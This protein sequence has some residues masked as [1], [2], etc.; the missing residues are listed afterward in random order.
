MSKKRKGRAKFSPK[1]IEKKENKKTDYM[2]RIEVDKSKLPSKGLSYP[3]S[4]TISYRPYTW[5]EVKQISQSKL[6]H[7]GQFEFIT[8]GIF[9][10]GI[11]VSD[12]TIGDAIYLGIYRK[13]STLGTGKVTIKY[14][15]SNCK[16][17]SKFSVDVK[18]IGANF[19]EAPALPMTMK[20]GDHHRSFEPLSIAKYFEVLN[21]VQDDSSIDQDF[22][23]YAAQ[24]INGEFDEV[25]E[26]LYNI[27]SESEMELIR[28]IDKYL[29]HGLESVKNTC[30]NKMSDNEEQVCGH[31]TEI[32]I[33][34]GQAL[35]L[36]FRDDSD[37]DGSA[38]RFGNEA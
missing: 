25:Y 5:G 22:A 13:I 26:Q 33:E 9:C 1:Q 15:C 17:S 32:E 36:P 34:G 11:D 7:K 31:V 20:L 14:K 27:T 23:F 24:C 19:M 35:L 30:K 18:A 4:S 21:R 10:D 3:K 37:D 8:E 16:K 6:G 12:L 28:Q 29:D 2:S 38:I